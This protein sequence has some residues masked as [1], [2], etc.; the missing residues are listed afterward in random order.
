MKM[1]LALCVLGASLL[2]GCAVYTPAGHVVVD[3][4]GPG[5]GPYH[6]PPGQAKKGRC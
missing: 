1:L 3:D 4:G 5:P 6:C 2:A